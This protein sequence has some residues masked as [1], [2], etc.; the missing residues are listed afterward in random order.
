MLIDTHCHLDFSDFQDDLDAIV[1]QSI[2]A[3]VTRMI[4]IG[5][6]L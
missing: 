3:G 6:T 1:E 2:A 4:S 5:T